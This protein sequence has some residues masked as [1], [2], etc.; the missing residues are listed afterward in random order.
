[1][2]SAHDH[3]GGDEGAEHPHAMRRIRSFVLREGRM[4]PAQQRAFDEH[5]TRFGIDYSGCI[6]D[7]AARFGRSA[8]L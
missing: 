7:Y 3:D 6:Q 8:P 1:M 4:T 2:S 5:W